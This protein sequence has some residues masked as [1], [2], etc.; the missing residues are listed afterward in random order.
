MRGLILL[1]LFCLNCVHIHSFHPEEANHFCS[2]L[3]TL[4]LTSP[5]AIFKHS[6]MHKPVCRLN[7]DLSFLEVNPLETL[8]DY[9]KKPLYKSHHGKLLFPFKQTGSKLLLILRN[10]KEVVVRNNPQTPIEEFKTLFAS[11][12]PPLLYTSKI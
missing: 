10:Y 5:F 11:D 4:E 3:L 2:L 7:G 1:A 6:R 8:I 12:S 9:S